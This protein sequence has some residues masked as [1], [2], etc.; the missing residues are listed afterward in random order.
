MCSHPLIYSSCCLGAR[1]AHRQRPWAALAARRALCSTSRL[2]AALCS[3]LEILL[4]TPPAAA[5]AAAAPTVVAS[6][7]S[8]ESDAA[9]SSALL[10]GALGAQAYNVT[11]RLV[12]ALPAAD[13]SPTPLLASEA[14][15]LLASRGARSAS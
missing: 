2:H 4:D 12:G 11:W 7:D 13:A 5:A 15:L 3:L 14:L 8:L 1:V 10:W 6:G 9:G